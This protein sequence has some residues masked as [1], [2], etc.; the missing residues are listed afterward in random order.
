MKTDKNNLPN[1]TKIAR[2]AI[3]FSRITENTRERVVVLVPGSQGKQYRVI[4]RRDDPRQK[5]LTVECHCLTGIGAVPCKGNGA[6]T[7][8]KHGMT[9]LLLMAMGKGKTISFCATPEDAKVTAR[10]KKGLVARFKVW[11][12]PAELWGCVS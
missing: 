4:V 8:C 3:P 12:K 6:G 5:G 10:M 2:Q 11:K 7:L 9:A 1:R